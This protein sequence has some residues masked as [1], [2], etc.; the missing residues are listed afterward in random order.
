MAT[1]RSSLKAAQWRWAVLR[2]LQATTMSTCMTIQ[3]QHSFKSTLDETREADLLLHVV[4]ISHPDFE[5]Q[6]QVVEN[7]LKELDCADKPSMI[8]F[9]K[10]DNYSWVEKEE[11]DL[12]PMEKENIPLEDLKKTWMAKLNEDCLFISAKNK[13]NIDEFREILYKKVRELHVQK[14][15]YNDFLYQDYE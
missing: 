1:A 11:D 2:A 8:I 12:T 10:I 14:Y 3:R 4:D 15:P 5:E 6:I 13:E 7:T 9:N